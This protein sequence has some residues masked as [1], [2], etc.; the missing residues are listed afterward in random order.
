MKINAERLFE[1]IDEVV[2]GEGFELLDVQFFQSRGRWILRVY[3]DRPGG[4]TLQDCVYV[5]QCLDPVLDVE[6]LIPHSYHLEVSSPGPERPIRKVRDFQ[7]FAGNKVRIY[8]AEPINNQKRITG[9]IRVVTE[10]TVTVQDHSGR[11]FEIHYTIIKK[12]HLANNR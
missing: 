10:D 6:D 2:S 5:S 3:I 4:V 1:V 11:N 12:A 7:R 9:V 8:L